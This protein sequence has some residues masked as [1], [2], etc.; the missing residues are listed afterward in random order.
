MCFVT[1]NLTQR[2]D[3]IASNDKKVV[4][5]DGHTDTVNPLRSVWKDKLGG[6]IDC[7]DGLLD[8][9][10]VPEENIKKVMNLL[11]RKGSYS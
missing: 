5:L 3:G 8:A 7:Y 4:Y 6:G 1:L 10:K 9:D 2:D 11:L